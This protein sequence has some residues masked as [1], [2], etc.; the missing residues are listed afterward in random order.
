MVPDY[1]SHLGANLC[2][3]EMSCNY[4]NLTTNL[5]KLCPPVTG[6]MLTDNMPGYYRLTIRSNL[7]NQYIC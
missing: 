2:F 7:A 1:W 3:N 5:R 4:P 6:T